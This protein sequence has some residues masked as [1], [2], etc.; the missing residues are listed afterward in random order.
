[1]GEM[2]KNKSSKIKKIKKKKK[3]HVGRRS[4]NKKIVNFH[5]N[6]MNFKPFFHV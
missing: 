6:F 5:E 4:K 3:K 1:M 2:T